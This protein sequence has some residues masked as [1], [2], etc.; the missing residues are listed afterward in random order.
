[1]SHPFTF[2]CFQRPGDVSCE[3]HLLEIEAAVTSVPFK[4]WI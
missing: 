1:M 2:K 3:W 4:V